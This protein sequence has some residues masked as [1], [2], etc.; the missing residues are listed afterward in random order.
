M[1]GMWWRGAQSGHVVK[2]D[3]WHVVEGTPGSRPVLVRGDERPRGVVTSIGVEIR[4]APLAPLARGGGAG[5]AIAM[6]TAA[7][8]AASET[9][10]RR[11]AADMHNEPTKYMVNMH[12]EWL[13]E[14]LL[15][16]H[17]DCHHDCNHLEGGAGVEH[18]LADQRR[19]HLSEHS[20]HGDQADCAHVMSGG[21]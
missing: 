16:H 4:L 13:F 18:E 3:S 11:C 19:R 12:N 17:R 14:H 9:W 10:K 5:R 21:E 7:Q 20:R 15:R 2:G 6:G 1:D 8:H